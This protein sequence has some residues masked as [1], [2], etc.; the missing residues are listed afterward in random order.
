MSKFP[1]QKEQYKPLLITEDGTVLDGN[2]RLRAYRELGFKDIWVS[3][4][5]ADTENN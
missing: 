3:V 1:N 5:K 2:M 4:V